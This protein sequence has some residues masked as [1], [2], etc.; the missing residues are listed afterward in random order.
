MLAPGIIVLVLLVLRLAPAFNLPRPVGVLIFV[1]DAYTDG[2]VE[3][4]G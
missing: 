2:G 1:P 4:S 3:G